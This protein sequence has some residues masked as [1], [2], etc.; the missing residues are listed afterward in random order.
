MSEFAE[1]SAVQGSAGAQLKAAREASGLHI[2][3]LAVQLK[4]PVKRIESLE[5]DR[6]DELPD[7]A[8][9][10]ALALSVCRTLK[11]DPASIL[12]FL[13]PPPV[14]ARHH[15]INAPFRSPRDAPGPSWFA[16]LSQPA[17]LAGLVLVMGAVALL[18]MPDMSVIRGWTGAVESTS[19]PASG[20][21]TPVAPTESIAEPVAEPVA[22][23]E[24]GMTQTV[25]GNLASGAAASP[26]Q[27]APVESN[28]APGA[29]S[30]LIVFNATQATWVQVTDAQGKVVLRRTLQ[31]GEVATTSAAPPVSAVVGRADTT[32]VQVRGQTLDLKPFVRDNVA[33]F[34][35]K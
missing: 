19:E 23:T 3:A 5:A 6:F 15:H 18:V 21:R 14:L 25:V 27:S 11:I 1:R 31:A 24:P 2:A 10:R 20:V 34:E 35:V 30:D 32:L 8:F 4:V 7:A 16:K 28:P 17:V 22:A 29:A 9:A 12:A 33:R 26:V 13:P